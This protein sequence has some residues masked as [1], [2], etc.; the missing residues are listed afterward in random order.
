MQISVGYSEQ[1]DTD[2][3]G[4]EAV[5]QALDSANRTDPC[6][7]VLLFSTSAHDPEYLRTAVQSVVGVNV[8]VIGGGAV[9]IISNDRFGYSGDQ[10]GVAAIWLEGVA[11]NLHS[12]GGIVENEAAAGE[13]LGRRMAKRGVKPDTPA[14]LFYDSIN[15]TRGDV[16]LNLATPLLEGIEK[17]LGFLPGHLVGAGLMGDFDCSPSMQWTGFE[18]TAQQAMMFSFPEGLRIDS[19]IMH[20]CRPSGEYYTVTK[21]EKQTILEV[22]GQPALSFIQSQLQPSLPAEDFPFFMIFGINRDPSGPYDEK[23]YANRLCL[24]IDRERSGIVM[25]ES[26]MVAGTRFQIMYRSIDLEYIPPRVESLFSMLGGRKPVFG[27]YIN[28]AGR[29]SRFSM[30]QEDAVVVQ[31]A[32][33]GRVPLLGIYSGVEIAPILGQPRTLDWTGVFC[34]FSTEA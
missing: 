21:A 30:D 31:N 1:Q 33:A 9:G 4:T 2:S 19:V 16:R 10:I 27:F 26:D 22:N 7:I 29:A 34:L 12:E 24:G 5:R 15:R 17:G 13:R 25:F 28:C 32:V 23:N 20:G 8:P 14:I 6:D 11:C 18:T 3:A